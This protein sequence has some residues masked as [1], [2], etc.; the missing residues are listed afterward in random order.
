MKTTLSA[1]SILLLVGTPVL[2]HR[3]DEYLQATL[4]SVEK[5]RVQAQI[6][7]IPGVAVLPIVLGNIDTDADEAI[8]EA[9]QGAYAERVLRDLS[10]TLDGDRLRLRLLSMRFPKVEEMRQGLGEIH[11]EF[12]AEV[13]RGGRGGPKRR[14]IFENHHQSRIAAYLVN[15]LVPQDPDIR[16]TAQSRNYQ[17]SLYELDYMQVG[18]RSAPPF[19]AWLSDASGW[20][21][22]VALLLTSRFAFLWR[23]RQKL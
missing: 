1:A 10:L 16:I 17:Q 13:P 3:L 7:L 8:S 4:I 9:E 19:F 21:G 23:Q 15:C 20:L 14:L 6:R 11:L 22:M 18:G 2:G 5:D 12:D